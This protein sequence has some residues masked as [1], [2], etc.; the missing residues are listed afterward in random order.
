[1]SLPEKEWKAIMKKVTMVV[2]DGILI[3]NKSILMVKRTTKPFLGY[4]ALPGGFVEYKETVEKAVSREVW[5]E[6]GLR[7]RITGL[8]GVYSNPERDPRG[9]TVS[10]T[11]LLE[12]TGGEIKNSNE[13]TD[14]KFI[15]IKNLPKKIAFDHRNIINDAVKKCL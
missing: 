8:L 5:E 10:V 7:T 15:P 4:Y 9:H 2:V 6:T 3:E 11:F 1:M 14:V 12:R 13:T